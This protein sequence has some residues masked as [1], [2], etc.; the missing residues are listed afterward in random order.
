MA[1]SQRV[2]SELQE[3]IAGEDAAGALNWFRVD[4]ILDSA[5]TST[6][7]KFYG[8]QVGACD[9]PVLRAAHRTRSRAA[10]SSGP[11]V[12]ISLMCQPALVR[13]P[14]VC[15]V[16]GPA[17]SE[18]RARRSSRTPSSSGGRRYPHSRRVRCSA[19]RACERRWSW[20]EHVFITCRMRVCSAGMPITSGDESGAC[21]DELIVPP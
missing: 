1:A 18:R 13:Q 5:A 3:R 8:L 14:A 12:P 16:H 21:I 17:V 10:A 2:L 15:D 4:M 11:R 6:T 20:R 19:S 9:G 7:T